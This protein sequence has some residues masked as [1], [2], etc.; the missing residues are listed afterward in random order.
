MYILKMCMSA[1][2]KAEFRKQNLREKIR[3]LQRLMQK[4]RWTACD[5]LEFSN[6]LDA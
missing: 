2:F 3:A 6:I 5:I 1:A 4:S